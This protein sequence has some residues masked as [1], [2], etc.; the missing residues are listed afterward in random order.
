MRG[1]LLAAVMLLCGTSASAGYQDKRL[2]WGESDTNLHMAVAFGAS[3]LG[4]EFLERYFD[5][6]PWKAALLSSVCVA[7]AGFFK[8]HAVD[9]A[10]SGSDMMANGV[11]L[12]VSAGLQFTL[13]F[14]WTGERDG[15]KAGS[16]RSGKKGGVQ[17]REEDRVR[18]ALPAR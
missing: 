10:P 13:H 9:A 18:E 4:A 15:K 11:G 12:G 16:G 1:I 8:E 14:D 3:F 6:K 5:M 2:R 7:G 17:P